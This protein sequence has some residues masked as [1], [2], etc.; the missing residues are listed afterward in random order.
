MLSPNEFFSF[1]GRSRRRSYWLIQIATSLTGLLAVGLIA[2]ALGA[3]F[4]NDEDPKLLLAQLLGLGVVIWPSLAVSVRRCH[5]RNQSGWFVLLMFIP[6]LGGMW[7]F[8]NLGC[9]EGTK[10]P[11]RFGSSPKGFGDDAQ[12]ALFA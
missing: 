4:S 9:L 5:D 10:A 8:I 2:V 12:A 11:N 1:Q 3:D 6:F 7:A